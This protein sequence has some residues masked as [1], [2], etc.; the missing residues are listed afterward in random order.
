MDFFEAQDL[1]RKKTK[2]LIL[3]YLVA[4][5]LIM[6]AVYV[7]VTVGV[8]LYQYW[9]LPEAQKGDAVAF[10]LKE[11][12]LMWEGTRFLY[13]L[14]GVL[15]VV[16]LGSL[17]KVL[18]LRGGGEAVAKS[19][20]GEKVDRSTRNLK[21]KQL[22]NIVEEM[23]IASGVPVPEVYILPREDS[24][25]A[26]AAGWGIDD[27]VIAV[28]AGA[29]EGLSRDELQGVV[30]HEYSHILNGDCRLNIRLMGVLFG[31][32]MLSVFGRLL[33]MLLRGRGSRSRRGGVYVGLGGARRSRRGG[34]GGGGGALI[35]AVI[36][37]VVLVTIIGYI[38]SFF[39]RLI[40]SAISRQR[41][42]LADAS[43]VQFTRNP[44]GIA[45]ALKRVAGSP[46]HGVLEHPNAEEAAHMFFADG[47]ARSFTSL[48]RTHP[49]LEKRIR[50]IQPDWDGKLDMPVAETVQPE[51]DRPSKQ[52]A[53][54][55]AGQPA[56]AGK[57]MIEGMTILAAAGTL[58]EASVASARELKASIPESVDERTRDPDGA[59][60]VVVALILADNPHDDEAQLSMIKDAVT[61][62]Y[63]AR[64]C[65]LYKRIKEL[66]RESR[67][68]LLELAASTLSQSEYPGREDFLSLLNNLIA[69]DDRLSFYEYCIRRILRE[70]LTRKDQPAGNNAA[71][72]YLEMDP[73]VAQAIGVVLSVIARE[74]AG[75]GNPGKLV[76]QAV[77]S[78]YLLNGKVSY[79][80]PEESRVGAFDPALDTL[81]A[82]A[83]AIRAQ[84]LRAVVHCIQADG[85]LSPEEAEG[86]R[87]MGLSLSVPI[88]PLASFNG[89]P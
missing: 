88:P 65:S 34:G 4:L 73:K 47:M 14:A 35:L 62:E 19:L 37:V 38:G 82:S 61:P 55:S 86:L 18:V 50:K 57:R 89:T 67:L 30:A 78:H 39:A 41:E 63:H 27:A 79:L 49:P 20:G 48:F 74:G 87:M 5:V 46:Y 21:R 56:E 16:G 31:I 36:I 29:L 64:I 3:Y 6:V 32:M 40:Q 66:P 9:I 10:A 71:I 58:N 80:P 83:F 42:Y 15:S 26:F 28:S 2:R 68:T 1:A 45:G 24:I 51:A 23:A 44:D 8:V 12:G 7:A 54:P 84:C 22:L 76:A 70:R 33:G 60:Q 77:Q 43:A 81:R 59:R 52:V 53:G 13:T 72:R 11:T 85:N 75:S 17:Y 25:N 69:V